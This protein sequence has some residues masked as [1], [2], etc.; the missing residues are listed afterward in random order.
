MR[1]ALLIMLTFLMGAA[2]LYALGWVVRLW[3][4]W[5]GWS[6][7]VLLTVWWARTGWRYW[8][9]RRIVRAAAIEAAIALS[10]RANDPD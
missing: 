6:I 2:W 5:L 7:F 10:D 8:R 1:D 3:S 9:L 4:P